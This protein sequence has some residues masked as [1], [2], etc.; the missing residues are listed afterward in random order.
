MQESGFWPLIIGVIKKMAMSE[1]LTIS[2]YYN[3]QGIINVVSY[4]YTAKISEQT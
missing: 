1:M 4:F 2:K 3:K